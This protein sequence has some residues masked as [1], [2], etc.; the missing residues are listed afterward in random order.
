LA[1]HSPPSTS[2]GQGEVVSVKGVGP[3]IIQK[4]HNSKMRSEES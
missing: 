1:I 3:R 4:R 2:L